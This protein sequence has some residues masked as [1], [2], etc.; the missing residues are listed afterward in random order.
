MKYKAP[1]DKPCLISL[2][3]S[4]EPGTQCA[5]P[6]GTGISEL[7]RAHQSSWTP[8]L[9]PSLPYCQTVPGWPQCGRAITGSPVILPRYWLSWSWRSSSWSRR[10][11]RTASSWKRRPPVCQQ[12]HTSHRRLREREK[13]ENREYDPAN[14]NTRS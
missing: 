3:P 5:S 9:D 14:P 8:W 4:P 12:C 11:C 7:S 2:N 1:G 10:H 6:L 13:R